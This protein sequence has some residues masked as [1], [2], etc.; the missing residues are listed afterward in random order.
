MIPCAALR[1]ALFSI[2]SFDMGRSDKSDKLLWA[3]LGH[4]RIL[5]INRNLDVS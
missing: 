2:F 3:A 4:V 5:G 1:S